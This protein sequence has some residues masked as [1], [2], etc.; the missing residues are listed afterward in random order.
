VRV[1]EI[2]KQLNISIGSVCSVIHNLWLHKVYAKLAAK[3]LTNECKGVLLGVCCYHLV[4][5][6]EDGGN[7][8]QRIVTGFTTMT[9]KP[10]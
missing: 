10:S 9:Q 6:C 5:Y 2:A 7:F 8:L 3:E 1:D 4:R